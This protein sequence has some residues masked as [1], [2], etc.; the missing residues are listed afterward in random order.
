VPFANDFVAGGPILN[1]VENSSDVTASDFVAAFPWI[2]AL[3]GV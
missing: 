3:L 1:S 2:S